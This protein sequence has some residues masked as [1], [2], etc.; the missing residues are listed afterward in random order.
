MSQES[1]STQ[2][3][4]RPE[5]PSAVDHVL[6]DALNLTPAVG[7]HSPLLVL[8]PE[9]VAAIFEHCLEASYHPWPPAHGLYLYRPADNLWPSPH[10]APLLLARICRRLREICLHTPSLWASIAFGDT[11]SVELL[12]TWL[13]RARNHPLRVLLQTQDEARARVLM[14]IV[15]VHECQWQ[16]VYFDLPASAH[17]LLDA[18]SAFP[19][20]KGLT[21][22]APNHSLDPLVLGDAPSLRHADILHIP[23][24]TTALPLARLTALTFRGDAS[25]EETL[26]ILRC[27]PNL[28]DFHRVDFCGGSALPSATVLELAFLRTLQITRP[29]LLHCLTVPRLERLQLD[30]VTAGFDATTAALQS[31]VT[32]SRCAL[33]FFRIGLHGATAA[34]V[35]DV[36]RP[37][38]RMLHLRL[39]LT[40]YTDSDLATHV[41]VLH[42]VD[43]PV[44]PQL[45]HLELRVHPELDECA[46]A[47]LLEMLGWRQRGVLESFELTLLSGTVTPPATVLDGFRALAEAGLRV[48]M[49]SLVKDN[50]YVTLLDTTGTHTEHGF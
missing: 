26:A 29:G 7:P 17:A 40:L 3:S 24:L 15:K 33:D 44:L 32:R 2:I 22:I 8:P 37:L 13:S 4:N 9:I 34:Q 38:D 1:A 46:G 27:C 41:R 25:V 42:G 48:N 11:G 43:I 47:Q 6:D 35:R 14:Q 31:L 21:L 12:E 28:V 5:G 50:I 45:K 20:L 30:S 19:R 16:E 23:R 49:R 10:D 18:I 39:K 36:L